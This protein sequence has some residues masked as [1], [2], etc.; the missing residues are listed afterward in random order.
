MN[1]ESESDSKIG[2]PFCGRMLL[3]EI[4]KDVTYLLC[5]HFFG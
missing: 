5:M 3:F 2:I 1:Q 4:A